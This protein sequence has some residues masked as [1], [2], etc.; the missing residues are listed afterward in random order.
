MSVL[1]VVAFITLFVLHGLISRKWSA[2]DAKGHLRGQLYRRYQL[3]ESMF[4]IVQIHVPQ[5]G[6][7]L[8]N[9]ISLRLNAA[10]KL[11]EKT[12]DEMHQEVFD[13]LMGLI[14]TPGYVTENDVELRNE[15]KKNLASAEAGIVAAQ[16]YYLSTLNDFN[17][18]ARRLGLKTID[19]YELPVSHYSQE[20]KQETTKEKLVLRLIG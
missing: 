13:I 6:A 1:L 14:E 7:M 11:D 10:K 9:I 12:S 19:S 8:E 15:L 3:I 20:A 5:Y 18:Y 16:N 4:H 2:T 17:S